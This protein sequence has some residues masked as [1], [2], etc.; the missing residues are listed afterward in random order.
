M[1]R[2]SLLKGT[3]LLRRISEAQ[4]RVND[5]VTALANLQA[6]PGVFSYTLSDTHVLIRVDIPENY[7]DGIIRQVQK[8]HEKI[9]F[10][11]EQEL[12]KL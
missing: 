12:K 11:L 6:N 1:D 4:T 2:V 9:L 10:D 5:C 8:D 3:E 7:V